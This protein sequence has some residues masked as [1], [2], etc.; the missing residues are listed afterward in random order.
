MMKTIH[1]L[2]NGKSHELAI[3]PTTRLID[4]L[5]DKLGFKG[6]K[7]GCGAGECGACTILMD[8]MPVNSC[9]ILTGSAEGHEIVTI[10]GIGEIDNLSHL[11]KAFVDKG[12]IQCGFCTPGLIL[13][14]TAF[15]R[16]RIQ[17]TDEEIRQHIAGNLCRCT[18]YKKIVEAVQL[19]LEWKRTY[20]SFSGKEV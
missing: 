15:I 10:E 19:A 12:A 9:L 4:V 20:A 3:D 17:S 8:G 11:Q 18:G 1:L 5:H 13:T 16:D 7:E 6:V 2:V 14:A